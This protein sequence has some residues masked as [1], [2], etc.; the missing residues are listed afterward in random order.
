MQITLQHFEINLQIGVHIFYIILQMHL[1]IAIIHFVSGV[2]IYFSIQLHS[3]S[4]KGTMHFVIS[5]SIIM[6]KQMQGKQAMITNILQHLS[7]H[8]SFFF[9][10]PKHYFS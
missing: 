5:F 7:S 6:Y 10:N 2:I 9:I 8:G 3:F 1:H 4:H